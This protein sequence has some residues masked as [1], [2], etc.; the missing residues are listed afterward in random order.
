MK[1]NGGIRGWSGLAVIGC[2]ILMAL[3]ARAQVWPGKDDP[4][5]MTWDRIRAALR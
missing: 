3:P 2:A 4:D 1:A 5:G